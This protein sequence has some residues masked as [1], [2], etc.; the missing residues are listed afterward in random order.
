MSTQ[1]T[2]APQRSVDDLVR[3]YVKIRDKL[4][5]ERRKFELLENEMKSHLDRVGTALLSRLNAQEVNSMATDSGTVYITM[6][7]KPSIRDGAA[8]RDW[9]LS[10]GNIDILQKRLSTTAIRDLG[11]NAEIP[12]VEIIRE[13]EIGV[14]RS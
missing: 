11:E 7:M 14:R 2:Q 3:L 4:S 1:E 8:L 13:A 12:G 5:E 10:T 6:K 9:I